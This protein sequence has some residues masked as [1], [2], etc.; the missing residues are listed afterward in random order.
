[1]GDETLNQFPIIM[2]VKNEDTDYEE[3]PGPH[4]FDL[5]YCDEDIMNIN[6]LGSK[7]NFQLQMRIS[8]FQSLFNETISD[9]QLLR[10]EA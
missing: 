8:Q 3:I 4:L 6:V 9:F 2:F 10:R 1:M 7:T 5:E